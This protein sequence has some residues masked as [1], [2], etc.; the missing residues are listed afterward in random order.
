[1]HSGVKHPKQKLHSKHETLAQFVIKGWFW[2]YFHSFGH[3]FYLEFV[4]RKDVRQ[5]KEHKQSDG[6]AGYK[7]TTTS[8][9]EKTMVN[10]KI[11]T[12]T[13]LQTNIQDDLLF[14]HMCNEVL[15]L[16]FRSIFP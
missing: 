12:Q 3:H 7:Q 13:I 11:I 9:E 1:M 6:Y 15:I 2:S 14:L 8:L 16:T 5:E 4:D 10:S